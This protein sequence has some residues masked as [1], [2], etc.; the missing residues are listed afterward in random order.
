MVDKLMN[1]GKTVLNITYH[2]LLDNFEEFENVI[3][4]EGQGRQ[5]NLTYYI[6]EGTHHRL[7]IKV[8]NK[9]INFSAYNQCIKP[10]SEVFYSLD[11]DTFF[12]KPDELEIFS[13]G[14]CDLD[15]G[16]ISLQFS[17]IFTTEVVSF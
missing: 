13:E 2:P 8:L 11:V 3:E 12:L 14:K 10:C 16:I 1:I 5:S 4:D 6:M 7:T 15:S 17:R 9:T